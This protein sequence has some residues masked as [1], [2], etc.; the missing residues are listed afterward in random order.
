MRFHLLGLAH[1]P[2]H[3]MN[4]CCAYTQKIVNLARMLK[5]LGHTVIFYGVEE[6][7]VQCDEFVQVLSSSELVSIYGDYDSGKEF[8][9]HS[10]NDAAYQAFNKRSIL[11]IDARKRPWDFLLIPFGL[12][13]K[14][15]ADAH[16]DLMEVETGIGY[17]GTFARY[18][19]F[20]SYA[21]MHW[22]YGRDNVDDG[23]WYDCVI[24]NYFDPDDF[25]YEPNKGDYLL[26]IGRIVKRKGVETAIRV[27][28]E[29]GMPLILAG[30]G[31]LKNEVEQLDL[32]DLPPDV[33]YI[34]PVGP[35]E[36][37]KLMGQAKATIMPTYYI[38][39]FG[40]VAVESMLCGTPV[41]TSDWGAFP[42]TILHGITGYRCR[43]LD[44]FVW[45]A[46]NIDRIGSMDCRKWAESN[47]SIHR[48]SLMYQDYFKRL[49]GLWGEGW[50]YIDSS[51]ED[52]DW[53]VKH[54]PQ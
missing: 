23:R 50:P 5:E 3:K 12:F 45:G 1:I 43:T 42:E 16:P 29:T 22:V 11:E 9:K 28:V 6:S 18:R 19:I 30:Q 38:E 53:M 15:I 51:R 40:G 47:Y 4:S 37:S 31:K 44:D 54:Y 32:E 21:W 34:G 2:T 17:P 10:Y 39:P 35:N 13:Q 41:L 46:R 49:M 7:E 26:Y 48:V 36:R 52:L 8:Y 25:A 20:E 33:K 14:P 24:P 27:A